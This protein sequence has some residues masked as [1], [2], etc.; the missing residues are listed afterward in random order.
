VQ[1]IVE[2]R[3]NAG[4]NSRRMAYGRIMAKPSFHSPEKPVPLP[5]L[6]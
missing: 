2:D 6:M 5:M 1:P 3:R 4:R